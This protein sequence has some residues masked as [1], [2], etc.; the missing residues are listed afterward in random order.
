MFRKKIIYLLLLGG[1]IYSA[2][3]AAQSPSFT[4]FEYIRRSDARIAGENPAGLQYLP[5]SKISLAEVYFSKNNGGFVNYYQSADNSEAGAQTESFFRLNPKVVLYGKVRYA[6]F[7]GKQMGGSTFIDPYRRTFDIQETADSTRG[8]KNMEDCRLTGAASIRISDRLILGGRIDYRVANYAKFKDLRHYNKLFDFSAAVG[9]TC[10]LG[11]RFEWGVNY[12]YHRNVEE[13]GFEMYG[14]TDRRYISLISF[15]AFYG[16][17]EEFGSSSSYTDPDNSNPAVGEWHGASLQLTFN[18]DEKLQFFNE[19]S[20]RMQ[21]GFFGKRSPSTPVFFEHYA[22]A[23]SYS[24]SFLLRSGRNQQTVTAGIERESLKNFENIYRFEHTAGGRTDVAYLGDN[25]ILDCSTLKSSLG[26]TAS[27]HVED[28]CPQWILKAEASYYSRE[29]TVSL[30]PYFRRQNIHAAGINLS[31]A[32]N[33][34]RRQNRYT[35]LVGIQYGSGGGFPWKD[36]VYVTPSETQKPPRNNDTLLMREYEYLTASRISG[37]TGIGYTRLIHS[38]I[39][40]Y[41]NINYGYT[42]AFNVNHLSGNNS[43]SL[44]LLAGCAF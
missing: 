36:G 44:N 19:L 5:V 14:T 15:G 8:N 31:A 23:W 12:F 10:A 20:Y 38:G 29:Q 1:I 3:L 4:E 18:K 2:R 37:V 24:A 41:V 32:R 30:Y 35:L 11:D 16:R 7:N 26:Y 33:I 27:L 6:N 22:P 42:N 25:Q 21:N 43:H 40:M 17:A 28:Y 9:A 34:V 39:S 13:I